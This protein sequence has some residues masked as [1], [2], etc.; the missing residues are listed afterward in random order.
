MEMGRTLRTL[1]AVMIMGVV[2]YSCS[3]KSGSR[4]D[5]VTYTGP[6]SFYSAE[7]NSDNTFVI[8]VKENY[9][10]SSPF[11]TIEGTFEELDSGVIEFTVSSATTT[12]PSD[13]APQEG[14]KAYGIEAT[15]FGLFLIPDGHSDEVIPMMVQGECPTENFVGNW[16]IVQNTEEKDSTDVNQ[17]FFGTFSYD[18]DSGIGEVSQ[19][20]NLANFEETPPSGSMEFTTDDCQDGFLQISSG[21]ESANMWLTSIGGAMVETFSEG[22]RNS[23]IFALPKDDNSLADLEGTFRGIVV[24]NGD[25][26]GGGDSENFFVEVEFDNSGVGVAHPVES[27]NPWELSSDEAGTITLSSAASAVGDGW[28]TGTLEV[29]DGVDTMSVN[30]SCSF[31]QNVNDLQ[32]DVLLCTAQ[33][34]GGTNTM[35]MIFARDSQ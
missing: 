25:S 23:T 33:S 4:T 30:I 21:D 12:G 1:L 3:S 32:R 22:E 15:G 13:E 29:T 19:K 9:D 35:S 14:D 11:M 6:G 24:D 34:P 27:I 2:I 10:D 8:S 26:E 28:Y 18:A 17:D 5:N 16:V 31:A 7:L 20:H